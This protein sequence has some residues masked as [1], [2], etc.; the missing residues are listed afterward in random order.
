MCK[1]K[2]KYLDKQTNRELFIDKN[3]KSFIYA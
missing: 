1:F 2:H 3:I